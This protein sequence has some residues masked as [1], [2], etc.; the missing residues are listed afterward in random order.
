MAKVHPKGGNNRSL[1]MGGEAS[2]LTV[3]NK[4]LMFNCN[5]FTVFDSK[6]DLV[7]RVDNYMH[8]SRGQILLMDASG[9]PLLTIR[10]KR[11]SFGDCWLV[12]EGETALKPQL[13]VRKCLNILKTKRLAYATRTNSQ[14]TTYNIQGSY[15]GRH[16]VVYD[17]N[18]RKVGELIRKEGVGDDVF[19]LVVHSSLQSPIA[20]ALVILLNQM[21]GGS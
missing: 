6:G 8:G 21:I 1:E 14:T 11:L 17:A 3:W 5:G 13:T 4:S 9:K 20:M 2:V 12:C 10:R 19:R 16:C 15:S 7:F 18:Q